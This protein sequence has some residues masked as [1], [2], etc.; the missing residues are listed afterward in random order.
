MLKTVQLYPSDDKINVITLDH[1][2]QNKINNIENIINTQGY[3]V[4]NSAFV[5]RSCLCRTTIL[6]LL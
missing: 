5:L 3:E 4:I 2:Q 6:K 1:Y